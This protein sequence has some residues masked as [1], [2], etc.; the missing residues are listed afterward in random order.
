MGTRHI[1]GS[2]LSRAASQLSTHLL[3]IHWNPRNRRPIQTG[4]VFQC[5]QKGALAPLTML[6][7]V[8]RAPSLCARHRS[9]LTLEKAIVFSRTTGNSR[10]SGSTT[11]QYPD[12]VSQIVDTVAAEVGIDESDVTV[13]LYGRERTLSKSNDNAS[14][15]LILTFNGDVFADGGSRAAYQLW[16]GDLVLNGVATTDNSQINTPMLSDYWANEVD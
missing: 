13:W 14:G 11:A 3:S 10:S 2:L 7:L 1:T 5:C 16:G 15:K 9:T 4:Q 6:R 8:Y 12:L